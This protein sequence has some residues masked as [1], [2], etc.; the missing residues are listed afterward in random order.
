MLFCLRWQITRY[1]P[2]DRALKLHN[3]PAGV[4]SLIDDT[5][6]FV[7]DNAVVEDP[8]RKRNMHSLFELDNYKLHL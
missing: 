6:A 4:V 1:Y 8:R 2:Y 3:I 5:V 7:V